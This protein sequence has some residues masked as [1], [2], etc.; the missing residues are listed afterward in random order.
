MTITGSG[1]WNPSGG[2]GA[3]TNSA[4]GFLKITDGLS[5][6]TRVIFSDFDAGAVVQAFTFECDLRIGNGTE[7]PADGFSVNYCRANDPVLTGGDFATGQNCEANLPEE[8]TQTGIS[9]GFDAWDSGGTPGSLCGVVDQNIGPDVAAVTVRVDGLL[10]RQYACPTR[11]PSTW[12]DPTSIQTGP[13]DGSGST[14]NLHW[15]HLKVQLGADGKLNVWWKGT[16]ILTDYQTTYYPSPGRLV[17][18]GRTGGSWQNQDVDNI[19][20]TTV[21]ATLAQAGFAVGKHD[22]FTLDVADSGASVVDPSTADATAL[23]NGVPV[24][25][26]TATKTGATTT[27]AYHGFPALLTSGGAYTLEFTCKDGNGNL[28]TAERPFTAP[29]FAV[30]PAAD[31]VTGVDTGKPG[32]RIRPWQSPGQPNQLYWLEEQLLGLHGNNEADLTSATNN[33]YINYEGVINFN[34]FPASDGYGDAGSFNTG[35]GYPDAH[36]PGLPG[37]NGMTGSTAIELLTFLKF[38]AAGYYTMVVNSDDGFLV[39]EGRNPIDRF[40]NW[41]GFYNGGK[42]ASD[43]AFNIAVTNAGIYPVRLVWENGAG[44]GT[45]NGANLEWFTIKDGVKYLINDPDATNTT[46]VAAY[47]LGPTLPAYVSHLYP[48]TQATGCRADKLAAQITDGASAV[49][50]GSIQLLLDGVSV[51]PVI[52]KAGAVTTVAAGFSAANLMSAGG[53]TATLI[54]SD[55]GG[56][57]RS[58]NWSFTVAPYTTLNPGLSVPL[59]AADTEKPGFTIT[60]AQM[61][62]DIARPGQN[63]G[64]PNQMDAMDALIGGLYFPY[65]GT[66]TADVAGWYS[67]VPADEDNKWFYNDVMDFNATGSAGDFMYDRLNPGIPG[68]TARNDNFAAWIEGW[69][70]LTAG[71]YRMSINS[72]DGFRVTQGIGITRQVLHVTGPGIDR[73]VAAV[74]T[75]TNNSSFGASLPVVPISAPVVYF[76]AAAGCPLPATDL[77]GKIAA[78][79]NNNCLDREY[80]AQAQAMGAIACVV[81]NDAQYGLPYVLGG[82]T[83]DTPVTIPVLCVNGFG[84][85]EQDVWAQPGLVATI[86]RDAHLEIGIA[87]YGKGMSWVNFDFVAPQDGLYPI[88]VLYE[89]GGGGAGFEWANV[90]A[91]TLAMQGTHTLINDINTPGSIMAYRAV[92]VQL[93]PALSIARAGADVVI[94]FEGILQSATTVNGTYTDVTGATSPYTTPATGGARF[95]RARR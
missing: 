50:Q 10:V 18:A 81:I 43:V 2:V 30:I 55:M 6:Q 67:G 89:Q 32:Y 63:D 71:Y 21:A 22:G 27:F 23:L 72:D 58:N 16:Q 54:W 53:H 90:T 15:A 17:F 39:S 31:A 75:S 93:P 38:D 26:I 69:L 45:G 70:P 56:T 57:S 62:P 35:N 8:G 65:Y 14:D 3:A 19:A 86:G 66:N 76:S 12:T 52:S 73:D 37:P 41:L 83:P 84:G 25:P 46:G 13:Y 59:A 79:N 7:S 95:Y 61:D 9:I 40:A 34:V 47:Y 78:I 48:H 92:T 20:I 28:I 88:H 33:G 5:Q 60:V 87:D 94:T 82:N 4:D 68:A 1:Y 74:V 44:E 42:G 51:N 11:N 49:N 24:T 77:T 91:E 29:T 64:L 85:E 36:F 80:A